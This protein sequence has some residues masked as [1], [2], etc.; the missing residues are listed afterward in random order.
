MN[1]ETVEILVALISAG[2]SAA[3]FV[4]L[5]RAEA[6]LAWKLFWGVAVW[7]PVLGP[8]FY[9]AFSDPPPPQRRQLQAT[10]RNHYGRTEYPNAPPERRRKRR[11]RRQDHL[12]RAE[13]IAVGALLAYG[14][15]HLL[16]YAYGRNLVGHSNFWGGQVGTGLI[17]TIV[18]VGTWAFVRTWRRRSH[19]S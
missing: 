15:V 17:A 8:L 19:R 6:T 13:F 5:L 7:F 11:A 2:I 10:V 16:L 4:R 12:R 9:A 3:L 18:L 1:L 14:W